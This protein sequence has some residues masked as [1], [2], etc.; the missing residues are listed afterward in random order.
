MKLGLTLLVALV[1][2][3]PARGAELPHQLLLIYTR[4]G[5]GLPPSS[6][7]RTLTLYRDGDATLVNL[8]SASPE[9]QIC[10]ALV[11]EREVNELASRLSLAQAGALS[12]GPPSPDNL[13]RTTVSFF[14]PLGDTFSR[15]NTFSYY[16]V[17][18]AY[19]S[20]QSLIDGLLT[21]VFGDCR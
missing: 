19:S 3:A 2:L 6:A 16:R 15:V 11:P 9:G 20:I 8:A 17:A 7:Y 1:A 4:E 10:R 12:G 13:P 5:G 21:S 18:G 14:E